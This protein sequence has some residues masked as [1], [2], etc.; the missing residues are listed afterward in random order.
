MS[1]ILYTASQKEVISRE[2][3]PRYLS[4]QYVTHIIHSITR[5][6]LM[7]DLAI[8][9]ILS[10]CHPYHIQHHKRRLSHRRPCH[11][12]DLI[13]MSLISY[14]ASQEVIT[15]KTLPPYWSYR[16]VTHIIY[17]ITRGHHMRDL[18]TLLILSICHPCYIQHHRRSSHERPCHIIDLIDRS[19]IS[20]TA[21]QEVI[22][23]ETLPHYW[24]YWYVT[25]IIYS[26]RRGHHMRDL[27]TLLILSICHPNH[28]QHHRRWS[29]HERPCHIIGLLQGETTGQFASPYIG[30][31][32]R[33]VDAHW[34]L[35]M[36]INHWFR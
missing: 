17:S 18:A 31:V 21:S 34:A 24:S 14:T 7:R 33:F 3:L 30:P 28:I 26:I 6:H 11:T 16:Y 10:I 27:A 15:W 35:I 1:L 29:S 23:W 5:G 25:H 9:L 2:T 20:Y 13:D 32:G 22:T 8:L 4:Y 12:I 36:L 19:P